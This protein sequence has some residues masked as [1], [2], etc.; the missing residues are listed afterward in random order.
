MY[1]IQTVFPPND[2]LGN[3]QYTLP[4]G[5]HEFPFSFRLP[6]NNSC[7]EN[8]IKRLKM[9]GLQVDMRDI[10]RHTRAPLPPTL[11]GFPGEAE[12]KY[13][14]KVTAERPAFYKENFRNVSLP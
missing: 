13:Y 11:G 14:V 10:N 7:N 3:S 12:I 8:N 1:N 2:H 6:F 9:G 5:Q 4:T